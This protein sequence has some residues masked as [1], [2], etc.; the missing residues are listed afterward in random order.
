VLVLLAAQLASEHIGVE[1]VVI[2]DEASS[3]EHAADPV[4]KRIVPAI[5]RDTG[6]HEQSAAGRQPGQRTV[7]DVHRQSFTEL[8]ATAAIDAFAGIGHERRIGNDQVEFAVD[9]R[10]QIAVAAM[11]IAGTGQRDVDLGQFQCLGVDINAPDLGVRQQHRQGYRARSGA[12]A[13]IHR[14]LDLPGWLFF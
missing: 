2:P 8:A 12:A 11:D 3:V 14:A 4:A 7:D 10:Q 5:D 1:L 9:S 6:V 13:D